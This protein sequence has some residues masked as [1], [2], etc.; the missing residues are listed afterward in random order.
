LPVKLRLGLFRYGAGVFLCG[1][2]NELHDLLSDAKIRQKRVQF[3]AKIRVLKLNGTEVVVT[4]HQPSAA[5]TGIV[6]VSSLKKELFCG[7]GKL[8]STRAA[9]AVPRLEISEVQVA[10]LRIEGT[11]EYCSSPGR[12]IPIA[13]KSERSVRLLNNV[14][15]RYGSPC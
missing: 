10:G 8:K 4:R 2:C 15:E 3:G 11:A 1:A 12:L 14:S 9:L 13:G 5:Q 7:L 6:V